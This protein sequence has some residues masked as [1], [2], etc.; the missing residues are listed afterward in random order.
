M[1]V[2]LDGRANTRFNPDENF[3]R[4]L[5]ELFTIGPGEYSEADVQ[6]A[7][8]VFTG[9]SIIKVGVEPSAYY[10][11]AYRS[12]LHDADAKSFSFAIYGDGGRTIPARSAEAGIYDGVDLL[13]ALAFH[14]ATAR[15]LARRLYAFFVNDIDDPPAAVV[16]ALADLYLQNQTSIRPMV[17]YLLESPEFWD[18][19]AQY[20]R[21]AWPAELVARAIKEVGW[22]GYTAVQPVPFLTAM[23]QLLFQPPN[24]GGWKTG[25]EW[26]S[27]SR[28]LARLNFS[29][30]LA[31]NQRFHLVDAVRSEAASPEALLSA[32]LERLSPAPLGD[33]VR[34]ELLAY[35]TAGVG[36]P[37]RG[38]EAQLQAK[39]PAVARMIVGAPEYQLL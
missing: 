7:S 38:G 13:T 23:G 9:W 6:A 22:N 1:L 24:V 36:S 35:F 16:E 4:E 11:F 5:L 15:R 37:W 14:P 20:R 33:V 8:R 34:D 39:V 29:A 21:Y 27:T 12:S 2:W 18:P 31:G 19:A 28:T 3:G 30:S 25:R 10:Q 26:F 17:R 32:L